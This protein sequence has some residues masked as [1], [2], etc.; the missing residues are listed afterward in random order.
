MIKLDRNSGNKI[1]KYD[2]GM[3]YVS[4]SLVD[5]YIYVNYGDGFFEVDSITGKTK[6]NLVFKKVKG[7]EDYACNGLIWAYNDIV[8][9]R[10][11]Q[12][13][14][15][16]VFDRD[17]LELVG[18]TI[19]DAAGIPESPLAIHYLDGYLYVHATSST[20]YVYRLDR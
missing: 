12:T 3:R 5:N 17:A 11:S 18:R 8:I 6:R 13:G 4:Y 15:M 14:D 19:V 2:S 9:V 16:A 7:L 20:V 10:R 1:W